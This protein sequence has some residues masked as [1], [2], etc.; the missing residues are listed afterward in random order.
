MQNHKNKRFFLT[1]QPSNCLNFESH[2][3]DGQ[4]FPRVETVT[5]KLALV[6][7]PHRAPPNAMP[8]FKLAQVDTCQKAI[9][10]LLQEGCAAR[11]RVV[12]MGKSGEKR[13]E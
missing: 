7:V 12:E 1:Y 13:R 11:V 10:P 8:I 9:L 6:C 4:F 2:R 5:N 3:S